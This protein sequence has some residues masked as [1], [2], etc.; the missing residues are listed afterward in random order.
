[1][2]K[3]TAQWD[4]ITDRT[5][6]KMKAVQ[7][8][9]IQDVISLAQ[10]PKAKGG[11]MPV[12]TGN[13]R[14]SLV[15]ELNGAQISEGADSF[16]LVTAMMDLGDT[17]RFAWIASYARRRE[18]GFTGKDK[19]GRQ[20]NEKGDHFAGSAADQWPSIVRKNAARL[21]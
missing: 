3:F 19:L 11:R 20:H 5:V 9:S 6:E 21:K 18:F 14:N 2:K 4:D 7:S 12:D 1:M 16:A 10:T 17:S 13:L 8:E 15:S